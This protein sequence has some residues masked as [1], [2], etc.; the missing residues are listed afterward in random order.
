MSATQKCRN[1]ETE[2][3]PLDP[4]LDDPIYQRRRSTRVAPKDVKI[5]RIP[6]SMLEC[7]CGDCGEAVDPLAEFEFGALAYAADVC[8]NPIPVTIEKG[9]EI[10]KRYQRASWNSNGRTSKYERAM[11]NYG[12]VLEADRKMRDKCGS[13]LTTVM[14]TRRVSPIEEGRWITPHELDERLHEQDTSFSKAIRYQLNDFEYEWVAVTATTDTAASPHEH[15]YLWI[16]DGDNEID[17]SMFT[18]AMDKHTRV[19]GA[20]E[21]K[22]QAG[23]A[24]TVRYDPSETTYRPSQ[25]MNVHKKSDT[26]DGGL[27]SNTK[28]ARYIAKQL[29]SLVIGDVYS[30]DV[31]VSDAR[32]DGATVSWVASH[33]TLRHSRGVM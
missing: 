22:H 12:R 1:E 24:I 30:P 9:A 2:S 13:S 25:L 7:G 18:T 11:T 31:S 32:I 28:G 3:E 8:P 17:A 15:Q 16:S 19:T 4:E 33:N 20:T 21:S 26:S 29:P 23:E 10:T 27:P 6:D 14:L 5:N